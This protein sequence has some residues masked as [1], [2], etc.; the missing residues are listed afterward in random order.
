M[1]ASKLKQLVYMCARVFD[2]PNLSLYN[3]VVF[4]T[5]SRPITERT[6]FLQAKESSKYAH[7]VMKI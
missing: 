4:P 6:Q 2:S 5:D 1:G 7:N 3:S